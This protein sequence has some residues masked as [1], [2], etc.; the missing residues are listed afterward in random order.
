[1]KSTSRS[2]AGCFSFIMYGP[3]RQNFVP[4]PVR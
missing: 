1:M 3:A 2:P 4:F